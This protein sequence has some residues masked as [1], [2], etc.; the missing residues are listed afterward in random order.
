MAA[1]LIVVRGDPLQEGPALLSDANNVVLVMKG[2]WLAK[3]PSYDWDT[4]NQPAAGTAQFT[5]D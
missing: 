1:D 2:G 3:A 5:L 4:L